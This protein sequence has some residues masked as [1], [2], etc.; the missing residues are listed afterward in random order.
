MKKGREL[1]I[2]IAGTLGLPAA[3]YII[4][5]ILCF[6]NG[7]TYFGS[8]AMWRSIIVNIAVSVSCAMGIGLQFKSGRF[9]FSGGSIMLV[10][11]IVAGNAAKNHDGNLVLFGVLCIGVCVILSIGVALVYVYGRLPI[12]ISTIGMALLYESITPLIFGGGGINLVGNMSLKKFS[13]YPGVLFPFLGSVA[14]YAVFSYLSKTGKQSVLLANNQGA[15]V[16]IGI[17]ETKNVII[18]YVYSGLIFGFATM[19]YASTAIHNASYTSLSTAGELFSNIL[20][21]FVGLYIGVFCG[22]TIGIIMGSISICLMTYGLQAILKAELGSAVST[23]MMGIFVLLVNLAAGQS[24][25]IKK[26]FAKMFAV[27]KKSRAA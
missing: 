27:H 1:M 17:N 7:K 15:A 20:P 22:D 21:V 16:N 2:K 5:M 10:A 4:M 19:I 9:D 14:V 26:I 25:N 6:A 13:V 8:L 23:A 3:M 12:M 24:G 18:S 11:A